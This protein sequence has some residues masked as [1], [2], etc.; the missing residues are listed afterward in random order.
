MTIEAVQ[1]IVARPVRPG[2]RVLALHARPL[3]PENPG[4]SLR[5]RQAR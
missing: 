5:S 1:A 3:R 4:K 2:R